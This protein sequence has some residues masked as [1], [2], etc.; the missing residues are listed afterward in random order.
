MDSDVTVTASWSGPGGAITTGV[1]DMTDTAPYQST[2]FLSSL[3]TS[4]SGMYTCTA[5]VNP[6][7]PTYITGS[8]DGS[9]DLNITIGKSSFG[10]LEL[11]S[12][13]KSNHSSQG[14]QSP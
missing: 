7:D 3:V 10:S 9:D 11:P 12:L 5:S 6:V 4:D 14:W 13:L 1:T 2:L 8:K